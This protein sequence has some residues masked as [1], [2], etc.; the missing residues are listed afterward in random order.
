M[1]KKGF[2]DID[3]V[4]QAIR[5]ADPRYAPEAYHFI[6]EALDFTLASR[7]DRG[8]VRGQVLLEGIRQFALKQFGPL[9]LMVFDRWNIHRT[10]DFGEIVFNM[11][12]S[13]LLGKTDED[14]REDFVNGYDFREAF[15]E[16]LPPEGELRL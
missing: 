12:D 4:I 6:R 1:P 7:E 2:I 16:S 9:T 15:G 3:E 10:E 13:G 14:S 8:H 5:R 11:V